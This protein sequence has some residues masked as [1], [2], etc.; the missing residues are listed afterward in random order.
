[1]GFTAVAYTDD[2][3]NTMKAASDRALKTDNYQYQRAHDHYTK[4]IFTQIA[5]IVYRNKRHSSPLTSSPH[6]PVGG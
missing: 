1:M 6:A 3:Q 4:L 5:V 2:G